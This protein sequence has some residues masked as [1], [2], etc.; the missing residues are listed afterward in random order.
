M[1]T[2]TPPL[3]RI[4]LVDDQR[5]IRSIAQ[6]ALGKLGGFTLRAC[7]S[8]EE[9]LRDAQGFAPDL[10]LLDVNMPVLDGMAT[11]SGLRE[12]GI[13]VPAVFFTARLNPD[14]MAR[15]AKLGAIGTIAKPFDPL[16]LGQQLRGL[17]AQFHA[18][19]KDAG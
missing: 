9:A 8:G 17:W 11:L 5:D 1:T 12:R 13:T 6:L 15:Y 10:V 2:S 14:D 3:A 16:K 18:G 4:L 7:A 19:G